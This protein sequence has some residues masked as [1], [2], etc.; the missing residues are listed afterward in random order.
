MPTGN[1]T[2]DD[3]FSTG[4]PNYREFLYNLV[5][6]AGAAQNF[7]GN[8]PYLRVQAGGGPHAGRRTES[9]GGTG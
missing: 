5:N 2:I 1:Q 3:R 8:G 6:F 4:G 7:D 9:E